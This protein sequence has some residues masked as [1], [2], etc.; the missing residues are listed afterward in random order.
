MLNQIN[1]FFGFSL[2]SFKH[3]A[4]IHISEVIFTSYLFK[5]VKKAYDYF[6]GFIFLLNNGSKF[7]RKSVKEN[8]LFPEG[9]D[10]NQAHEALNV[11]YFDRKV[12]NAIRFI[13][14]SVV[15]PLKFIHFRQKIDFKSNLENFVLNN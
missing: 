2:F 3:V 13:F 14:T 9:S 11:Y 15:M 7:S 6:S 10:K 4:F 12:K 8:D 1:Y 5:L